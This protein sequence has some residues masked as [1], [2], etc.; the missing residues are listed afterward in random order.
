M[1]RRAIEKNN[2][3]TYKNKITRTIVETRELVITSFVLTYVLL[4]YILYLLILFLRS[5]ILCT[6]TCNIDSS[7]RG[8]SYNILLNI[9]PGWKTLT[10]I[11]IGFDEDLV[12]DVIFKLKHYYVE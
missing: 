3:R 10:T 9:Y 4:Y 6:F 12:F 7:M 8:I 2:T 11:G 1:P 5:I